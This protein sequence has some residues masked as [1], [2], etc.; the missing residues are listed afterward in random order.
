M[1]D[2]WRDILQVDDR[3]LEIDGSMDDAWID[4]R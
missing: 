3:K 4:D 1:I 2:N